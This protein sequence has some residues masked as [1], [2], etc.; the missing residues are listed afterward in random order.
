MLFELIWSE[1]AYR[2]GAVCSLFIEVV[3]DFLCKMLVNVM[4]QRLQQSENY[5]SYVSE[6][7]TSYLRPVCEK[8][9]PIYSSK[10]DLS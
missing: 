3:T 7:F 9:F 4:Q 2:T 10:S 6:I 1:T 5:W 8:A